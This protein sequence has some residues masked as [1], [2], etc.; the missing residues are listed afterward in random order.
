MTTI[1]ILLALFGIKHF[2]ADFVLQF[3][4]MI[5]QKGVYG[6]RGGIDHASIH[7]VLTFWIVLVFL[8]TDHA[9]VAASVALLDTVIHYH[10]DW[11]KQQ[12]SQ[13]TT[14][15]D[16]KFWILLGGDQALHYLTYIL[17]IGLIV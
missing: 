2:I 16:R 13:G 4:Y 11:A 10:I 8:G 7:G 14:P 15:T 12:L 6:A 1:L 9:L 5:G 3:P 17:I